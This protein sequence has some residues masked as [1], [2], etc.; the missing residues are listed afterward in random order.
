S[1]LRSGQVK[2]PLDTRT[3]IIVVPDA[4]QCEI[5]GKLFDNGKTFLW[6]DRAREGLRYAH[7][8][9]VRAAADKDVLIVVHTDAL[10]DASKSEQLSRDRAAMVAAWFEG[11]VDT[12]LDQ[13]AASVP[14][15]ERWGAREDHHML[16]ALGDFIAVSDEERPTNAD[17]RYDA[18]VR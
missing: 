5:V 16:R 2:V 6:L 8:L 13:Y 7:R 3:K 14:K 12:W 4:L 17:A 9:A 1:E 11:D 18:L 10:S 15:T